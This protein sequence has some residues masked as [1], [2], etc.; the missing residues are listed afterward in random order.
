MQS[1]SKAAPSNLAVRFASRSSAL[2]LGFSLIGAVV[3]NQH[4]TLG[5]CPYNCGVDSFLQ[6]GPVRFVQFVDLRSPFGKAVAF[7]V[8]VESDI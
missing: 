4:V 8:Y 7:L 5:A 1:S 3:V 2:I 6:F